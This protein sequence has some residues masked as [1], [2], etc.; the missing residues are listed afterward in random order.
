MLDVSESLAIIISKESET[1]CFHLSLNCVTI[2]I[3]KKIKFLS[4]LQVPSNFFF[5]L[6][7]ILRKANGILRV[8]PG[9]LL[10]LTVLPEATY[11]FCS[12]AL[13]LYIS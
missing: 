12:F 5:F 10:D 4:V 8:E 9:V 6:D 7:R 2:K 11:K 1:R 13:L 3:N